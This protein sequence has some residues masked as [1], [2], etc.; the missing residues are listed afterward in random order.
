MESVRKIKV[1]ANGGNG[2]PALGSRTPRVG[3]PPD[4]LQRLGA[5]L[6]K[7]WKRYCRRLVQCQKKFSSEGIHQSRV[8][9][10]RLLSIFELLTPLLPP[11]L[12]KQARAGLKQHLDTFD[13]LRDTQVQEFAVREMEHDFPEIAAFHDYLL[14]RERRFSRDT[15]RNIKRIKTKGLGKLV[16]GA[17]ERVRERCKA[18]D[19]QTI[20]DQL[21][22]SIQAAFERTQEL[23]A[24]IDPRDT[25]SIHCT[26]IAFKRFRY[27]VEALADCLPWANEKRL[28]AMHRYQ[29]MMGEI[30]DAEVLLRRY[31]KFRQKKGRTAGA[32][33]VRAELVR[34]RQWLIQVYL[35]AADQLLDFRPG[36]PRG[37]DLE[38]DDRGVDSKGSRPP[39][40]RTGRGK[41]RAGGGRQ[42][43]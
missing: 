2:Q 31:D 17:R 5:A 38:A 23:R 19:F 10:R 40:Q 26:R 24:A 6:K 35:D 43:K 25:R 33:G 7:Q 16:A 28:E 14:K 21:L 22:G 41:G 42:I 29:T 3:L 39:P 15:R 36:Q 9:T 4:T 37:A 12:L 32:P 18:G 20:N 27:M 8:E 34:R 13:D 30:Q 1:A 11:R